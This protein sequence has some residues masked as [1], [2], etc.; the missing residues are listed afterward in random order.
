MDRDER[1]LDRDE[2]GISLKH[3][4]MVIG[5]AF[6]ITLAVMIGK[7][8]SAEAMAVVVGIVCGVLASVPASLLLLV[9]LGRGEGRVPDSRREAEGR[10]Y[11]PVVI[12]QGGIPQA[13]PPGMAPGYW[14]S[15]APPAQ[16][17][18]QIVGASHELLGRD[19][20]WR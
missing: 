15:P 8:M 6:A 10:A 1:G 12:V 4:V 17:E 19:E 18:F 20:T 7:R 3:I 11:P 13:L 2:S 16:R 5:L 14:P 9:V